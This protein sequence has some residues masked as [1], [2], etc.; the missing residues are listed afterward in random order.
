MTDTLFRDISEHNTITVA[1]VVKKTSQRV[2]L[3][4]SNDGGHVDSKF[5][6]NLRDA[7]AAVDRGELDCFGVYFTRSVAGVTW[8]QAYQTFRSLIG[9]PHPKS[10]YLIDVEGWGQFVTDESADLNRVRSQM[11]KWLRDA[12]GPIGRA[13]DAILRRQPKRVGDYGNV[14]DLTALYRHRPLNL[15]YGVAAY[16]SNPPFPGK[17]FH[18]FADDYT[19]DGLPAGDINSADGLSPKQFA[20]R[21]GCVQLSFKER[22]ALFAAQNPKKAGK[23]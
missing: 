17:L 23:K 8:Q 14:G 9:K 18:Q 10:F 20:A 3:F 2:V 13:V 6:A 19:A 16:G 21:V 11:V 15:W 1:D 12:R 4:R 22:R 7:K 5:A